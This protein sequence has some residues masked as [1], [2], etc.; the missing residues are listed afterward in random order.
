MKES[1]MDRGR[2]SIRKAQ[3]NPEPNQGGTYGKTDEEL[4]DRHVKQHRLCIGLGRRRRPPKRGIPLSSPASVLCLAAVV[5]NIATPT[6]VRKKL[7]THTTESQAQTSTGRTSRNVAR[8]N[9]ERLI[10]G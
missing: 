5:P 9:G 8:R 4:L 7:R 1:E 3:S 2:P 10:R 6:A